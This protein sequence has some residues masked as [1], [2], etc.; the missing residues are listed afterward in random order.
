MALL[1]YPQVFTADGV[2]QAK[3]I[4]LT[5]EG[6]G[7]ETET[8][9]AAETPYVLELISQAIELRPDRVVLDYGCGI[10]RL[11][12]A[13][14]DASG[15]TVIGVD[16][17]PGMLT[18]ARDYVESDRFM[19]VSPQQFDVLVGAGL[20]TDAFISVWVLQ[21]CYAPAEDISRIRSGLRVGGE[22]FVLNMH[23][24]AVPALVEGAPVDK[25]FMWAADQIDV[26]TLLSEAFLVTKQAVP[27]QGS[28]PNMANCGAFWMAVSG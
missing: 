18:L 24:R 20:R 23:K 4:I 28:A 14:I 8:R 2:E 19:A 1:Y 10:G 16:V 9:W 17:S 3:S 22:G 6:P 13:M 15:C 21:H 26:E 12:K 7:A 11:S 5:N 25:N 27:D